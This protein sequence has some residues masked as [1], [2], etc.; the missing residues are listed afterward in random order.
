MKQADARVSDALSAITLVLRNLADLATSIQ[1]FRAI[2]TNEGPYS[3]L[4][5]QVSTIKA[6]P[7]EKLASIPAEASTGT[8]RDDEDQ[9]P[10]CRRWFGLDDLS[11]HVVEC[12][13]AE[14]QV[15]PS[16]QSE[17]VNPSTPS[18]NPVGTFAGPTPSRTPRFR[19]ISPIR[20]PDIPDIPDISDI[21]DISDIPDIPYPD[22]RISPISIPDISDIPDPDTRISPIRMTDIPDT[23]ISIPHM[24]TRR[25]RSSSDSLRVAM[26]TSEPASRATFVDLSPG[27]ISADMDERVRLRTTQNFVLRLQSPNLSIAV[28]VPTIDTVWNAILTSKVHI[29]AP[30]WIN[31]WDLCAQHV[32]I[33]ALAKFYHFSRLLLESLLDSKRRPFRPYKGATTRTKLPS[34]YTLGNLRS[35]R[36]DVELGEDEDQPDSSSYGSRWHVQENE[37]DSLHS[38]SLIVD[39]RYTCIAYN[40]TYGDVT[41]LLAS[42]ES[43]ERLKSREDLNRVRSWLILCH[44]GTVISIHHVM[45]HAREESCP[46]VKNRP[47]QL[48]RMHTLEV[49]DEVLRL[50]A[51]KESGL[52]ER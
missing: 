46:V 3:E 34:K 43:T 9:C 42:Q 13:K 37:T 6:Q 44:D 14:V 11:T 31:I 1:I 52:S 25:S 8:G 21:S 2:Q 26:L 22:T 17:P 20:I 27:S 41:E 30:Q 15:V 5:T 39:S 12:P 47:L 40:R 24:S 35:V 4:Y 45:Y 10:N 23:R 19:R 28:D 50:P 33:I 29:D 16:T 7:E 18:A 51:S 36:K 49:L 48:W 38:H 32:A